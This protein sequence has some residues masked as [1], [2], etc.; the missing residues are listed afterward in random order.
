MD[1][2]HSLLTPDIEC[3]INVI[4]QWRCMIYEFIDFTINVDNDWYKDKAMLAIMVISH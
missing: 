1:E 2:S 3:C 4:Y